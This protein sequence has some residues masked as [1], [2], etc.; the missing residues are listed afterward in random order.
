MQWTPIYDDPSYWTKEKL[1]KA[2][3]FKYGVGI[4]FG[5]SGLTDDQGPLYHNVL[6]IDS[7]AVHD[8]LLLLQNPGIKCS[9]TK[10]IFEQGCVVKTRKPKGYQIHWFSH[11]QHKPIH[12]QDCKPGHEFEIH[13]D[14]SS[15]T[16]MLPPSRHRKDPDF[17]YQWKVRLGIPT[18]D[19]FYDVVLEVLNDCLVQKPLNDYQNSKEESKQDSSEQKHDSGSGSGNGKSDGLQLKDDDVERIRA[20]VQPM[21]IQG[22]RNSIAFSLSCVF[23]RQGFSK[24]SVI[25]IVEKLARNDGISDESDIRRAISVVEDVFK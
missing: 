11:K 19:D 16:C 14:K 8:K 5:D 3:D 1:E 12:T 22:Y 13:T 10:R 4:V 25:A 20:L 15:G 2:A 21:Y 6:D 18:S 9:L 7:D 24:D 23:R 17:A